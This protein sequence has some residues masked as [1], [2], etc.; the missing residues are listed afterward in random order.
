MSK[1]EFGRRLF[2]WFENTMINP[3]KLMDYFGVA[4]DKATR[5]E[6]RKLAKDVRKQ[7]YGTK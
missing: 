3:D 6:L 7:K 2:K 1:K 5:D 4:R